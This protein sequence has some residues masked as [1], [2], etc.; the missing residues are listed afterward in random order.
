MIGAAVDIGALE[1]TAL[2]AALPCKLDMDGDNQ[3]AATKEG[4]VILR[5]MLGLSEFTA[6][7][8]TGITQ[9]QWNATRLNLNANCGTNFTP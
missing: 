4:L 7:A 8:G 1:S 9:P 5:S 3:V 2:A 6:V